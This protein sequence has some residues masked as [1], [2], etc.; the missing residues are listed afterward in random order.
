MSLSPSYAAQRVAGGG[1][2][3][4]LLVLARA[5]AELLV[6]EP[7]Q[8]AE[9]LV[10]V[11]TLRRGELVHRRRLVA[12]LEQLLEPALMVGLQEAAALAGAPGA[13]EDGGGAVAAVEVDGAD[14]RLDRVGQEAVAGAPAGGLFAVAVLERGPVALLLA[15]GG[16]ARPRHE[17]RLL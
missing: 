9:G 14:Q 5:P 1:L 17:E 2:L 11:G 10:V 8:D 6:G 7:D 3:R 16:E 13:E 12:L 4:L 15:P